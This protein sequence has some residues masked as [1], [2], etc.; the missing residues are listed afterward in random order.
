VVN[1]ADPD[2]VKQ[3]VD[4]AQHAAEHSSEVA[5]YW[6]GIGAAVGAAYLFISRK[7]G[8]GRVVDAIREEM[9]ATRNVMRAEG[10]ETREALAELRT[11]VAHLAGRVEGMR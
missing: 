3:A 7:M 8:S 9:G 4:A 11:S 1:V 5:D 6:P 2:S 10:K